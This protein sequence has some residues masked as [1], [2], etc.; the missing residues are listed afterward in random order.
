[1]LMALDYG[2]VSLVFATWNR[3]DGWLRRVDGL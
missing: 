3:L 1:L 2:V